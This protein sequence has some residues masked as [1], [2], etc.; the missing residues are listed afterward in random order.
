MEVNA[1]LNGLEISIVNSKPSQSIGLTPDLSRYCESKSKE[2]MRSFNSRGMIFKYDNLDETTRNLIENFM[3]FYA[4]GDVKPDG[5]LKT[6]TTNVKIDLDAFEWFRG[7]YKSF[8]VKMPEFH[9]RF[10]RTPKTKTEG[11]NTISCFSTGKDSTYVTLSTNSQ[12]VH[13]TR[14]NRATS[15]R[16]IRALKKFLPILKK[17]PI[18]IP[19]YSSLKLGRG[20]NAY[21]MRDGLIYAWMIP[22]AKHCRANKI[23]SGAY[24]ENTWY[25]TSKEGVANLN[26]L[27]HEKGINIT[28]EQIDKL[29]EEEIIRRMIVQYPR[30]FYMTHPCVLDDLLFTIKRNW[31]MKKF[32]EYPLMEGSCGTCGK[33]IQLNM[34]RLIHDPKISETSKNCQ[35]AI[36][37]YYVKRA[38]QENISDFI[39]PE[40]VEKVRR[41]YNINN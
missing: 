18:I 4:I 10:V 27:L 13:V 6:V 37:E 23:Y 21:Q 38:M 39:E 14:L 28:I 32:P 22:I 31:F 17:E 16:E 2:I 26:E 19:A 3:F 34:A 41:K 1:Q 33:D 15:T 40:L 5:K 24:G 30:E 35:R 20:N 36:A 29:S 9:A 12:P 7:L 11:D 25:S 8:G